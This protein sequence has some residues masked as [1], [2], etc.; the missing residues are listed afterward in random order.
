MSETK[1]KEKKKV[2]SEEPTLAAFI[3][4]TIEGGPAVD[5]SILDKIN[6]VLEQ[7]PPEEPKKPKCKYCGEV[8]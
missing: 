5:K 6:G 4:Q 3:E 8:H 7:K 1:K 2:A